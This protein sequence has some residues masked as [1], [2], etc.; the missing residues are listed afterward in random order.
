MAEL[1]EEGYDDGGELEQTDGSSVVPKKGACRLSEAVRLGISVS[2]VSSSSHALALR[3]M[4][5]EEEDSRGGGEPVPLK[6]ERNLFLRLR[7][8]QYSY[9]SAGCP[10]SEKEHAAFLNG[11]NAL[12]KVR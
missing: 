1:V 3:A 2:S 6:E 7:N 9:L 5:R 4:N 11:L 10:W 8:H 12:G